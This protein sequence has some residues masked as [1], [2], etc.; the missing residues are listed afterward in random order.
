MAQPCLNLKSSGLQGLRNFAGFTA[1]LS[2]QKN[3]E[4]RYY[5]FDGEPIYADADVFAAYLKDID[6]DSTTRQATLF[7]LVALHDGNK[8]ADK[9]D[10][11]E[12]HNASFKRRAQIL[13]DEIKEFEQKLA[14]SGRPTLVLFVPEHGAALQG[15]KIQMARLRDIPSKLITHVPVYAKFFNVQRSA[16]QPASS[17]VVIDYPTSY[18]VLGEIIS[19]TITTDY[20]QG[21]TPLTAITDNLPATYF[22]SE[23]EGAL[24]LRFQNTDFLRL[25]GHALTIYPQ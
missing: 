1:A 21:N 17:P 15:D 9:R 7:N 8:F 2:S 18:E 24:V 5:S 22:V 12:N 20:F 11:G 4:S 14:Q 10:Q 6:P 25:K 19:R 16:E 3:Y 23:N 13:L